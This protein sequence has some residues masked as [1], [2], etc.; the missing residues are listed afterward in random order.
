MKKKVIIGLIVVAFLAFGGWFGSRLWAQRENVYGYL[1]LF[2]QIVHL[3]EQNYVREMEP[4]DLIE[5]AIDGMLE[6]LDP[7]SQ[8]LDSTEFAQLRVHTEGEFGGLG[9]HIDLVNDTLT[10]VSPMEGTPA[11]RAGIMAGDR[12]IKIEGNSTAGI[13]L[14]EAVSKLR[15]PAGTKVAISIQREGVKQPLE[16]NL[17]REYIQIPAVPYVGPLGDDIGYVRLLTFSRT[18]GPDLKRAIDSLFTHYKIKKLILDLRMNS[19]GLLPEA[20]EVSDL[21][22]P[23][24]KSI[25]V[26]KGRDPETNHEYR[27]AGDDEYGDFP[28]VVLVD[29]GSASASEI[30]AGAIQDWE[31]GLLIGDTTFGKGSVQTIYQVEGGGA[32]KLTGAYWYTP[33]GRGID[34][35]T[36]SDFF[37]RYLLR[38]QAREKSKEEKT[39]TEKVFYTLGPGRY[40]V[41]GN[42]A[43]VPDIIVEPPKPTEL[44]RRLDFS[45]IRDYALRYAHQHKDLSRDFQVTP[46]MLSEV[47][48]MIKN[49]KIEF[50][51]AQFDSSR[52]YIEQWIKSE[53]AFDLFGDKGRYE[54]GVLPYDEQVKKAVELLKGVNTTQELFR[55]EKR[56]GR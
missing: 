41:F 49:K 27:A 5:A 48:G 12:V 16:Y 26:T 19:G 50:T 4:R 32:L 17:T 54:L 43:I 36:T 31:R 21:F 1:R 29:G 14:D 40:K 53:I 18:S 35:P 39:K 15:G 30:V 28:L 23:R 51:Q 7:H 13:T 38:R 6:S 20:I 42:G 37:K 33:S 55:R 3:V 22:L 24:G 2:T 44:A 56:E 45:V 9:I 25:V 8:Y 10:V 46:E 47:Q 34:K 52:I 11:S